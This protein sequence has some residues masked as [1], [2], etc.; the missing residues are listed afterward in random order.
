MD[1]YITNNHL[2]GNIFLSECDKLYYYDVNSLYP[3]VMGSMEMPVGLPIAFDGDITLVDPEAYG[4]F[5]C[6][7]TSPEYLQHPILQRKVKT[8]EGTRTIAGREKIR[9]SNNFFI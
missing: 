7:I 3:T 9:I 5:Y 2:D 8:K 1:V 4:Y 6:E